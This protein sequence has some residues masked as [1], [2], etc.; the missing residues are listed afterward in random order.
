[1]WRCAT[2]H[3]RAASTI[4]SRPGSANLS[5]RSGIRQ[6]MSFPRLAGGEVDLRRLRHPQDLIGGGI[7]RLVGLT[8]APLGGGHLLGAL[9]RG[10][11]GLGVAQDR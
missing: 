2:S 5:K 8:L 4:A 10:V 7:A 9:S 11:V 3:R 6:T 1:M